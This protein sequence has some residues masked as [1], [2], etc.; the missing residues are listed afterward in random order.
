MSNIKALAKA[1]GVSVASASRAMSNP[2]RVSDATRQKVLDA[3]KE[4]GYTPNRIGASL[5]T[6]RSGNI[7][8]IIPDAC[9][10]FNFGIIRAMEHSASDLGYSV[11]L[12]DT[13][14]LRERELAYGDMIKAKQADALAVFSA[15]LPFHDHELNTA[16]KTTPMVNSCEKIPDSDIPYIAID[17]ELAAYDATQHLISLGHKHIGVITGDI[18]TPSATDRLNGYKRALAEN[19]ITLHEELI[20][21][22][23]Y[24]ASSGENCTK[25]LLIKRIRPTAIFC[26]CDEIA[27]GC[28][29]Q[30][31]N[32]GYD[33]PND[34]SIIGID[35]I[36]FAKYMN[37]PLTTISQPV[38]LIGQ[39]CMKALINQINGKPEESK[40]VILPHEIVVRESTAPP[41]PE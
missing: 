3:A 24:S 23:Q 35:D 15:R 27:I 22:G 12:G 2:G 30:L 20:E 4:I 1:A 6:S 37:P 11:L 34:M 33:V 40:S 18:K 14:G 28:M 17:N 32:L 5:R 29:Y 19:D 25:N 21:Y 16:G 13:Q 31:T 38:S 7:L 39:E 41:K 8:V 26:F 36:S 9:D 10:P